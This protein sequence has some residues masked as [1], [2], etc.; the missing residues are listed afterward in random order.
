MVLSLSFARKLPLNNLRLFTAKTKSQ[1][2][3][4][5]AQFFFIRQKVFLFL[6]DYE[7]L[8]DTYEYI[9]DLRRNG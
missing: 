6:L 3:Y 5:F 1:R 4:V 9:S 7:K 2:R 8:R